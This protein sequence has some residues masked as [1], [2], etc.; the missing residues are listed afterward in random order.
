VAPIEGARVAAP[1]RASGQW[2]LV[3]QG[4]RAK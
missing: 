4:E 2:R 1:L 3:N